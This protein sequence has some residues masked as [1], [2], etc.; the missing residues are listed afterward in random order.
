[1]DEYLAAMVQPLLLH[2]EALVV[3]HVVDDQGVLLTMTVAQDDMGR[4]I[5]KEGNHM[6]KIR[7]MMGLYGLLHKAKIAVK[8]TEPDGSFKQFNT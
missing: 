6:R 4:I 8:L 5:G 7:D 3:N 2:P 1:M